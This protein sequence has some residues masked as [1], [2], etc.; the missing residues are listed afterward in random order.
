MPPPRPN[1]VILRELDAQATGGSCCGTLDGG[2]HPDAAARAFSDRRAA[3]RA[4]GTL[5]EHL[6]GTFGD[7]VTVVQLDPRNLWAVWAVLVR[8]CLRARRGW[9]ALLRVL[10][11]HVRVPSVFVDGAPVPG[12]PWPSPA[13]VEAAVTCRLASGGAADPAVA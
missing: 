5:A 11:L 1:V 12:T 10:A 9:R 8:D 3:M 13:A 4:A 7:A 2:L 6:A